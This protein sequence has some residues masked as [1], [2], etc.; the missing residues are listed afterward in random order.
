MTDSTAGIT[1]R[2]R[3]LLAPI[4][5]AADNW[6]PH[7]AAVRVLEDQPYRDDGALACLQMDVVLPLDSSRTEASPWLLFAHGGA[8]KS[9]DRKMLRWFT[10]LYT[11]VGAAFARAGIGAVI[12]G[13][14]TGGATAAESLDDLR[15]AWR[16]VRTRASAWGLDAARVVVMGHSAGAH[17]ATVLG[18]QGLDGE[19]PRGVIAMAGYYDVERVAPAFAGSSRAKFDALFGGTRGEA[20]LAWSPE[21]H[22]DRATMP[23]MLV[24]IAEHEVAFLR[25]EYDGLLAACRTA[26]V[27]VEAMDVRGCGHMGL[28]L[29]MGA[30]RDAV[31]GPLAAFVRRVCAK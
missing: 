11:N 28:M 15:A 26:G 16:C 4:W 31:T 18:Q 25:R 12:A 9:H 20:A 22:M 30:T 7:R 5:P 21:R 29:Q 17:L 23:P 24:G 1:L 10:G 14:R 8:F 2:R 27:P 3:P 6:R 13:Y 19:R